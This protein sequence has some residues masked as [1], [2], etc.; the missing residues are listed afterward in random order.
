LPEDT[1]PNETAGQETEPSPGTDAGVST[2][3]VPATRTLRPPAQQQ[4]MVQFFD[5]LVSSPAYRAAVDLTRLNDQHKAGLASLLATYKPME[6]AF[7][8]LDAY[9]K[10]ILPSPAAF[11]PLMS[12][13]PMPTGLL[14]PVREFGLAASMINAHSQAMIPVLRMGTDTAKQLA[15][16]FPAMDT[17]RIYTDFRPQMTRMMAPVIETFRKCLEQWQSAAHF[18]I[19]LVRRAGEWAFHLALQ[20]REAI[21]SSPDDE[22]VR[23]FLQAV[24][25][26]R[27][28]TPELVE[29]AKSVLLEDSWIG[30]G[31]QT[32]E[33]LVRHLK[34]SLKNEHGRW[35]PMWERNL[36]HGEI[37]MLEAE[38]TT[39][40]TLVD[41]I[42]DHLSPEELVL[43]GQIGDPLAQ[44]VLYHLKPE[45]QQILT[46]VADHDLTWAEAA[47]ACGY[48]EALG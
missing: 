27:R 10:L 16:M 9:A 46:T 8:S 36:G 23:E 7:R 43:S 30:V 11:A 4:S 14:P 12:L 28:V 15:G 33:T 2:V 38:T 20:T 1:S 35:K 17:L 18:G 47:I 44:Y 48:P 42:A 41:L 32:P 3:L 34:K 19:G 21:M 6:D 31:T 22:P 45:Q 5:T 13:P 26:R 24:L 37:R 39:G 25:G 29:A 40:G